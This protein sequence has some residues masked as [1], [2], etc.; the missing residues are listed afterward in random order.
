MI[1]YNRIK[2]KEFN[3]YLLIQRSELPKKWHKNN[4][5]VFV[6]GFTLSVTSYLYNTGNLVA[7]DG[8]LN[9]ALAAAGC[10][11]ISLK[12][13]API[14]ASTVYE[15]KCLGSDHETV[16]LVCFERRC[17]ADHPH[18]MRDDIG[19]QDDDQDEQAGR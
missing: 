15:A 16:R 7:A 2:Q 10:I 13:I 18:G 8:G 4:L 12:K 5:L 3:Q 1:F 11:Q 14:G 6:I 9:S 17:F 19:S